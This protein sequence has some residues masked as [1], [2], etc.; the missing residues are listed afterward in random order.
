MWVLDD[1][2]KE[3]GDEE[4]IEMLNQLNQLIHLLQNKE[5]K[6]RFKRVPFE[7]ESIHEVEGSKTGGQLREKLIMHPN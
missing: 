4:R 7:A 1:C 3:H 6:L 2:Y 5:L